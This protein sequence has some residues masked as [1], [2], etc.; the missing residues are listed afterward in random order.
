MFYGLY[1]RAVDNVSSYLGDGV[2]GVLIAEFEGWTLGPITGLYEFALN[3]DLTTVTRSR[4][5]S[6]VLMSALTLNSTIDDRTDNINTWADFDDTDGAYVDV[7]VEGRFTDDNPAASPTWTDWRRI[8][9]TEEE[10]RGAQ[11]R[12]TLLTE[13]PDYNVIVEQLRVPA[14][15]VN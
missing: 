15:E 2:S 8:D 13:S 7:I 9:S 10:F 5:R 11:F 14:D 12:A 6:D 4:V 1:P 3:M